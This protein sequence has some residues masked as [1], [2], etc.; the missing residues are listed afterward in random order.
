MTLPLC[1]RGAAQC[2]SLMISSQL[3]A[4]QPERRRSPKPGSLAVSLNAGVCVREGG[5][6]SGVREIPGL[7]GSLRLRAQPYTSPLACNSPRGR[8]ER[9]LPSLAAASISSHRGPAFH[10]SDTPL[11]SSPPLP[12]RE[13]EKR[14]RRQKDSGI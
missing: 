13:R 10:T 1:H 6:G 4:K 11:P 3:F 2:L 5:A 7:P 8:G 12:P 14:K 9:V